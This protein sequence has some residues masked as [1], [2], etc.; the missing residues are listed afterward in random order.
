MIASGMAIKKSTVE[1]CKVNKKFSSKS[2][3]FEVDLS[4]RQGEVVALLG[5]NGAGKTT[6][7]RILTGFY[8]PTSGGGVLYNGKKIFSKH[9]EYRGMFGYLPE[10]NPLYYYMKVS[11]YLQFIA[12]L[13][14][15]TNKK[16]IAS[17]LTSCGLSKVVSTKIEELSKGYKQ[18]VGLAAAMLGDPDFLVLDEPTSGLDPN[19]AT[20]I[21]DVIKKLAKNKGVLLSTHIL[22]EVRAMCDRVYI[23]NRG[24]IV[25][26]DKVSKI[27]NIEKKFIELT[28]N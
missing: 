18:R 16:N 4:I 2:V 13:K 11:E 26:A 15:E 27:K 14:G 21:R 5:P 24:K 6:L 9:P 7:M 20:E 1:L 22:S 3:L 19:Q 28:N 10:N 23:I 17:V 12:E 25:L 8:T